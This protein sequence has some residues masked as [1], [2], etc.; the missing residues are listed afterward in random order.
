VIDGHRRLSEQEALRL[1]K[2]A[3]ELQA[4][5]ADHA[6]GRPSETRTSSIEPGQAG[7]DLAQVREAAREVGIGS[8]YV[9]QALAEALD[10]DRGQPDRVDRLAERLSGSGPTALVVSRTYDESTEAVYAAVQR[11]FPRLRLSLVDSRGEPVAGGVLV[12]AVPAAVPAEA[13]PVVSDLVTRARVGELHLRL[14][15]LEERRCVVTLSAPLRSVHRARLGS[16]MVLVA[17]GGIVGGWAV[18][19]LGAALIVPLGLGALATAAAIGGALALGAGAG[20][21]AGV[22]AHRS[23]RGHA[24]AAVERLLQVLG[25]EL[26][27]GSAFAPPRSLPPAGS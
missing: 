15:A 27:L 6:E 9:D 14:Q 18:G 11:V 1:W 19:A 24:R 21:G 4:A 10:A 22:A 17:G 5:A 20:I 13:D 23:G 26:K 8:E 16:G 3:A 2:R 12:F 7:Y 25:V